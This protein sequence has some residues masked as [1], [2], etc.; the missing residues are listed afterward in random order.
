[1][2]K[3]I[4][5]ILI[6]ISFLAGCASVTYRVN[7]DPKPI[8]PGIYP[9]VRADV[10]NLNTKEYD[11]LLTGAE[12]V[13]FTL[14]LLD[15]PLAFVFDTILLPFDISQSI[16][17]MHGL[18]TLVNKYFPEYK[19]AK[20]ENNGKDIYQAHF[21]LV[22]PKGEK[23][24]IRSGWFRGEDGKYAYPK[25]DGVLRQQSISISTEEEA[26]EVVRLIDMVMFGRVV[27]GYWKYQAVRKDNL[28]LVTILD[29]NEG[30]VRLGHIQELEID[31]NNI[32]RSIKSWI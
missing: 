1:M 21:Y 18:E 26:I 20:N 9:S 24:D 23:I 22:S 27:P 4:I 6:F 31:K 2:K 29:R 7:T 14:S 3:I 17:G 15:I 11:P 8:Q 12:P 32:L 16:S 25:L 13:V 28:W 10:Q 19:I 5:I 30:K